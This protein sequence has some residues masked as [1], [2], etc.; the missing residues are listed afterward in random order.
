MIKRKANLINFLAMVL[1]II[2]ILTVIGLL[3]QR[4]F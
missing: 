3:L 1:V 4:L 2:G